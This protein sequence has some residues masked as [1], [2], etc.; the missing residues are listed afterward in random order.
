MKALLIISMTLLTSF[1][2]W[3]YRSNINS[4]LLFLAVYFIVIYWA[5]GYEWTN[6]SKVTNTRFIINVRKGL[7]LATYVLLN[8]VVLYRAY[9]FGGGDI[10]F[11][12]AWLSITSLLLVSKW[13]QLTKP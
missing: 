5:M 2:V 9:I 1:L 11:G 6:S 4:T 8:F 7:I 10:F 13:K 3:G 12:A